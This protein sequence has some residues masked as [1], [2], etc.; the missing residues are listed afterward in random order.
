MQRTML[1]IFPFTFMAYFFSWAGGFS[2]QARLF[3]HNGEYKGALAVA[4]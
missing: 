2:S 3:M 4:L 1:V